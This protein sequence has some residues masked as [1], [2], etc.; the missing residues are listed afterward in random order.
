MVGGWFSA[1]E[2]F[3][4][5][6]FQVGDMIVVYNRSIELCGITSEVLIAQSLA[7]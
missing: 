2:M 3:F 7:S 5:F 1:R 6:L 4:F